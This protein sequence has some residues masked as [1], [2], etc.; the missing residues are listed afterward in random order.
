MK[1]IRRGVFETN[2][3]STHS[4]TVCT[5]DEYSK[6][7]NGEVLLYRGKFYTEEAIIEKLK[8]SSWYQE[9]PVDWEDAEVVEEIFRDEGIYTMDGYD[10]RVEDRGLEQFGDTFTTPGGE[11][12]EIF[13]YYGYDG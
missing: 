4:F 6:W 8:Q 7:K 1:T 11:T 9:N 2:S 3:S 12:I 5:K 10:E 13:G